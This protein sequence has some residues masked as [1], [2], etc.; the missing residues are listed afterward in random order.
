MKFTT[1]QLNTL[2]QWEDHFR[3]A[4]NAQWARNPGTSAL[5][6]IHG[7]FCQVTGDQRRFN[8]NCS[9][10]I[11]SLLKD[12]GTIYFQD[13]AE[14]VEKAKAEEA[15][16]IAAQQAKEAEEASSQEQP[17]QEEQPSPELKPSEGDQVTDQEEQPSEN[18]ESAQGEQ[19]P[20]EEVT[21]K[22]VEVSPAPAEPVE[23]V[24]IKT[25]GKPKTTTRKPRKPKN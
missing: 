23:K 19:I 15:A 7:I 12:C 3:T 13:K 22:A 4:V 16:R 1:E 20:Q 9:H 5:L 14:M 8:D 11:L 18:A 25:T 24:E 21:D 10:C 2:S 17:V 6:T